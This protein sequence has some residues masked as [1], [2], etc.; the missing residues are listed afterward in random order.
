MNFLQAIAR[1]EGFYAPGTR[2]QRNHNPGD[3]EWGKF[4]QAHG[5]THGDPRFA[6]FPDDETGF[7]AMKALFLA[8]SYR[9]LTVSAALN[10]W[11]P[12]IENDVS[13]YLGNVCKWGGCSPTDII[14]GLL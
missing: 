2:P 3:V 13:A 1:E 12:P 14:D 5:A 9:G 11:A 4:A 10:R 7:A 8:S 6:V